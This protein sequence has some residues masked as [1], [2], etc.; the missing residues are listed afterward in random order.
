MTNYR[1]ISV[2]PVLSRVIKHEIF[3][4]YIYPTFITPLKSLLLADWFAFHPT[5]STTSALIALL[6]QISSVHRDN[7]YVTILSL[8][9]SRAFNTVRHS[10]LIVKLST[11]D[12]QDHVFNWIISQHTTKFVDWTSNSMKINDS[13]VQG[14]RL[15]PAL[16]DISASDLHPVNSEN[17]L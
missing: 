5:G 2:T 3:H 10:I 9:F 17:K 8:D 7:S 4:G 14:S 6:Q 11:V 12:I 1:L 13:I 16:Y 15:G